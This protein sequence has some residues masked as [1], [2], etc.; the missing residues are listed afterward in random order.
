MFIRALAFADKVAVQSVIRDAFSGFP[1][2][3]DHSD[4]ELDD[5]WQFSTAEPGFSGLV[6]VSNDGDI[7]GVSWWH[8]PSLDSIRGNRLAKFISDIRD[9]RTLVWED[10]ILVRQ[11]YQNQGIGAMLRKAFIEEVRKSSSRTMILSRMRSDNVPTL[12]LAQRLGF[13]PTGARS[14]EGSE[15]PLFQEFWYLLV[16]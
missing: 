16:Q 13:M 14:K 11:K 7:V 6:A 1:W 5:L 9:D 10:A 12:L 3:M 15:P 2:Y 8:F 4:L